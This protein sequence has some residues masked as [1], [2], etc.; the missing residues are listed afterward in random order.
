MQSNTVER[1]VLAVSDTKQYQ[2]KIIR[3]EET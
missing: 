3:R 1:I 2:G